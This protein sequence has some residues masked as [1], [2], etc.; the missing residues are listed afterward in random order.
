VAERAIRFVFAV[1]LARLLSPRDFGLLAMLTLLTDLVSS[2]SDLGLEDALVQKRD[3]ADA[4]R[5]S[6]FWATLLGGAVLTAGLVA[7]APWIAAFYG[8]EEL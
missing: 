7:G 8:V 4:H 6:V 1:V 3:L 2:I 5:S